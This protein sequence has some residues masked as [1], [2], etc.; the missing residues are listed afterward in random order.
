MPASS[1]TR[2]IDT[3]RPSPTRAQQRRG[4]RVARPKHST[5]RPVSSPAVVALMP[6]SALIASRTGRDGDDRPAQVERRAAGSPRRP[7]T[8]ERRTG[9]PRR[10]KGGRGSRVSMLR[11][12][13]AGTHSLV[14]GPTVTSPGG[15]AAGTAR[16]GE[17]GTAPGPVPTGGPCPPPSSTPSRVSDAGPGSPGRLRRPALLRPD[18]R[19]PH[20][21]ARRP[22]R[23]HRLVADPRPRLLPHV[24]RDPRRPERR[25]ARAG[26]RRAGPHR[27]GATCRARTSS[28]P[29]TSPRPERSASS[30][31]STPAAPAGCRGRSSP[32]GSRGSRAGSR[33]GSRSPPAPA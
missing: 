15:G 1:T 9:T 23:P 5:G 32:A 31:R 20:R 13:R 6:R 24:R 14:T 22:R 25:P 28:R 7:G 12:V 10:G 4:R 3:P 19:H 26:P 21:R 29:R 8:G 27:R 18:R 30:T 2:E 16:R 11:A 17:T 33:C